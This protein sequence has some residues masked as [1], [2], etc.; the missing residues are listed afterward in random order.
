MSLIILEEPLYF[1]ST[2][3]F[4]VGLDST[5]GVWDEPE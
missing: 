3:A 1:I 4:L 5:F 2:H